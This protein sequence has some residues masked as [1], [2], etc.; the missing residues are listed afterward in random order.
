MITAKTSDDALLEGAVKIA[1]LDRDIDARA[2]VDA[3]IEQMGPKGRERLSETAEGL[4]LR[5]VTAE[6]REIDHREFAANADVLESKG[7]V[8][9]GAMATMAAESR[10]VVAGMKINAAPAPAP[11]PVNALPTIGALPRVSYD[12]DMVIPTLSWVVKNLF[13]RSGTGCIYGD[14]QSGKTFLLIHLTLC[15]AYGLPFF[16]RKTKQGG[17][18]IVPAENPT[19]FM[20]RLKSAERELM[21]LWAKAGLTHH[22]R[23]PIEIVTRPPNL[24]RTGNPMPLESSII[25]AANIIR[26]AG[27]ELMMVGVDTLHATMAGG[28]EKSEADAHFVID[29][30]RRVAQDHNAHFLFVHHTGK[31]AE[32]GARGSSAFKAAWDVE[33]ELVVDGCVGPRA[34]KKSSALRRGTTTKAR[35]S[36]VGEEFTYGLRQVQIGVDEDGEPITTCVVQEQAL[37]GAVAE[38]AKSDVPKAKKLNAAATTLLTLARVHAVEGVASYAA[39]RRAFDQAMSG[40]AD[41]TIRNAWSASIKDLAGTLV[42][43]LL[44]DRIE[45]VSPPPL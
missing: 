2:I 28:D 7:V 37:I 4:A 35:D 29:P 26:L 32:N 9:V 20:R 27:F 19:S 5:A 15:I 34:P 31:S 42:F 23:A 3:C 24:S 14:S 1:Q 41:G 11:A 17:V 39:V 8:L 22:R 33:I 6:R 21:E 25:G 30:A 38:S 40:K 36:E 43:R 44:G 45:I 18:V 10:A 12:I 13:P 16:G